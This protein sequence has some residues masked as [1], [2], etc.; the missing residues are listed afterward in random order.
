MITRRDFVTRLALA[1]TGLSVA[2]RLEAMQ[3]AVDAKGTISVFSKNLHWLNY[4]DMSSFAAE[5]GFDGIDLTVRP[6]GHVLPERVADDLPKA[7]EAV[8]KTGKDV[9]MIVTALTDPSDPSAI[10]ILKTASQLGIQSYRMGW[11][12]YDDKKS[13]D[14]NLNDFRQRMMKFAELNKT[15]KIRGDYQNHSGT[16]FG[17]PVWDLW[18]VIK[19][20]DAKWIASQYDVMHGYV[21]GGNSWQL[22]LRLL[23]T[24]LGSIDI[25]DFNWVKLATGWKPEVV[26]LGEGMVDYK[27][28]LSMLRE[29]GVS[30]PYSM[31]FE[32]PLGGAE[33]GAKTLT[34]SPQELKTAMKRDLTKF[35]AMLTEAGLSL[36]K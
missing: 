33:N 13:M 19:Q 28:Y 29:F 34:I 27:K 20:L 30:G 35:R 22:G 9:Y 6:E 24:H 5:I 8:R 7:V 17:S 26:P 10:P 23:K 1:T 4:Q 18:S 32:Y 11:M 31:H 14:D 16:S 21:E 2:S 36:K 3:P 25:K 15:Y 12:N